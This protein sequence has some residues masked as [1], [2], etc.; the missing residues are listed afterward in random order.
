MI[1]KIS[2]CILIVFAYDLRKI[3]LM[4]KTWAYNGKTYLLMP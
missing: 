1:R 4:Y 3:P 2:L